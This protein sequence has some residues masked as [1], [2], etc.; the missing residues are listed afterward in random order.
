MLAGKRAVLG[1]SAAL[2]QNGSAA[3]AAFVASF[4]KRDLVDSGATSILRIP[5]FQP[6]NGT[7]DQV[8]LDS[9]W[10]PSPDPRPPLGPFGAIFGAER[11]LP[12]C[13]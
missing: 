10:V 11:A 3:L 2:R 7:L 4:P 5:Y 1:A 12:G 9:W 6:L 13:L 8:L